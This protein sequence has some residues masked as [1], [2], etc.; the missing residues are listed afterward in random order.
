MVTQEDVPAQPGKVRVTFSLPASIWA[1]SV[2]L[3]GDFNDWDA[4][5]MPLRRDESG[6]S[7]T[8]LLEQNRPYAYWYLVDQERVSDWNADGYI[9]GSDGAWRS[10]VIPRPASRRGGLESPRPSTNPLLPTCGVQEARRPL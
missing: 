3:A 2:A 7:I 1:D 4:A 9:I 8:L 6:W 10:V 5:P